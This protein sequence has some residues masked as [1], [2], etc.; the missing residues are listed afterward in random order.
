M[1]T[2]YFL[3]NVALNHESDVISEIKNLLGKIN[4]LKFEIQGV[5]GIY[6]VVVKV[7]SSIEE[8]I[9][10]TAIEKIRSIEYIQSAITMFVNDE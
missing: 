8:E 10:R 1:P 4:S 2:A 7:S 9:R 3:L 6:D 5:F